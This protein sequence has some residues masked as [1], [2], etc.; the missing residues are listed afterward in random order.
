MPGYQGFGEQDPSSAASKFNA[1]AFVVQALL[2]GIATVKLVQVQ[3]VDTNAKTVDVQPM[4]NQLDGQGN[5]SPHGT[6]NAVPYVYAQAGQGAVILDPAVGDKGVMVCCDRDI[7]SVI[8]SKA[9]ANPGSFRQLDVA[10]GVYLFGLPGLNSDPKQWIKFTD[11]GVEL[12]DV[13]NNKMLSN[14]DGISINGIIFNRNGQVH[15]NLPIDGTLQLSG[16]INALNGSTYAGTI[17]TSGNINAGVGTGRQV[18]LLTHEHT[19]GSPGSPTTQPI[20]N[21]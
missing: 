9:I 6:I 16:P 4:V 3:A 21:T 20:A 19:S 7:S 13:N 18:S 11:T 14:A 10:D 5:A 17:Q 15:G 8:S 2:A 12:Q 1:T